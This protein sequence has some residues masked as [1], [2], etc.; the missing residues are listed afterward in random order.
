MLKKI[1]I[2]LGIIVALFLLLIAVLAGYIANRPSEFRIAR[3]TVISAPPA[4]IFAQVND[5][6]KWQDW[7][8]W[9]K[10]DPNARLTYSGPDAGTG[11][12]YNWSG[13]DQVGEG[14]MT[15]TESKPNDLVR[16]KLDFL[17]P[18]QATNAAEFTFI[19]KGDQTQVTWSMSGHCNFL[20]KTIGLFMDCDKMVGPEFEKGLASLKS[21]SESASKSQ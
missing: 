14:R 17:K 5:L 20:M 4:V 9:A 3:S 8:P 10:L 11:A 6:H 16:F 1:L 15:V 13:N 18:F 12:S 2:G 19:P 21:V 7:S